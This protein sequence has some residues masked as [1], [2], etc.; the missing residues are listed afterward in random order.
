MSKDKILIAGEWRDAAAS[1]TFRAENPATGQ[2]LEDQYPTS[3]WA[4]CDAALSAAIDAA[5]A[6]R[7]TSSQTLARFL[8]RYADRI[9]ARSAQIVEMANLETALPKSPRLA[10]VELPRTT[11]Q[12]R[13]AASAALEGSWALPTI[14]T[15]L[16]IRSCYAPIGPVLVLGPNNFPLAF[17]GAGG[18]DF[19]AAIASGNPVIAKANPSHPGTTTLLAEEALAAVR[20]AELHPATVQLI[21][22][23][24]HDDGARMASDPRMGAVAFTGSRHGGLALK[25]AADKA[26]KPIYLEMSSINPV[27]ILP[28]ALAERAEKIADEFTDSCLLGSGQFCTNP[29]LV[30]LLASEVTERF[31]AGVRQRF[32]A[33]PPAPLLARGVFESL[34]SGVARLQK[35]GAQL[36]AGGTPAPGAGSRFRN[37][38]LRVDSDRFLA[39]P[40]NLQTEAFGNASLFVI[41][42]DVSAAQA[43]IDRLEGNLTGCIYSATTGADDSLYDALVPRLRHRV[44]RLLNDKM[45]TGVAVSPAMNHGG[46]YPATGHPGFTAVGIPAALRRFA[47]LQCFDNVRSQRLPPALQ[48]RNPNGKMW[49]NIDGTWTTASIGA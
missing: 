23:M 15:K 19:A 3:T 45:P 47:M 5:L 31:I 24:G 34:A 8:N 46:P 43:V 25:A 20:E 12:L 17:N 29:G 6:L 2:S 16:N 10:D 35:A 14:D 40:E 30:I 49:R 18:G 36:V 44:G 48:D 32:D 27:V 26:G 21:Y 37:T 4:D 33:R 39:D 9:E 38:L 22:K 28:G 41:A 11:N 13:Q 7:A 42:R 1:A